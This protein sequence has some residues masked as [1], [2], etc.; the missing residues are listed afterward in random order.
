MSREDVETITRLYDEFLAKPERVTDPGI[1]RFFD[2][3]VEIR[4]S[5][6]FFGTEGTFHGYEGLQRSAREV[7]EVFRELC[8][9]PTRIIDGGDHVLATVE[10]RGYGRHSRVEVNET[11]AHLWT[12]RGGRI[13]AWHVYMDVPQA[14]ED[15]GLPEEAAGESR[16]AP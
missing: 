10:A 5:A 16:Q 6:S 12:L 15:A 13:V 3:S 2:P 9:V 11:V 8:W 1:L 4:Q 14:F 7:F